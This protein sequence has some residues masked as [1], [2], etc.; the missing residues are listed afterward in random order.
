VESSE[1]ARLVRRFYE[2]AWNRWDDTVVGVLLADDFRFRGSLGDE[3]QGRSEWRAYR[4]R[5]RQAVPDFHNEIVELV[6]SPGRAAVRLLFTGHHTGLL[7]GRDGDGGRICYAGAAFF[8]CAGGQLT[9]AWV[10]G[11]L[12]DLRRQLD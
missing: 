4:D 2:D 12:D 1:E 5:V 9:S 7:L 3:T 6:T 10:L 11:D 8:H